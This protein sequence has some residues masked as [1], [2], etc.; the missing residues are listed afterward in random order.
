MAADLMV[1]LPLSVK[2][3]FGF[4]Q[5]AEGIKNFGFSIF[6]LFYYNSVLGLPGWMSGLAVGIALVFDA[7]TDPLA[8]SL[9][10]RTRTSLGRRHPYMYAS[11]IPLA[12]GFYLLFTPPMG[13]SHWQLFGWMLC[14]AVL[15]RA[16]MTLFHV[17]HLSLG[18]ELTDC[19]LYTSDAADE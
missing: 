17:P 2:L 12:I 1:R 11:I 18:A 3:F 13:L 6:L 8:G 15:T 5:A 7:I 9:S 16:G 10:D 4:G 19:L 14:F